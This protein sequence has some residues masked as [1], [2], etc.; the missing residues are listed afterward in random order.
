M[1]NF[2]MTEVAET[3]Y[4]YVT[5]SCSM[6]PEAV[7]AAMSEAFQAVWMYMQQAAIAPKG[8][9][10]SVY[11]T[12]QEDRLTFRAGFVVAKDDLARAGGDIS[13][14]VTPAGE[15]LHFTH[16]GPYSTLRD[17]YALM[18]A[19]IDDSGR[20]VSAPTWEL[21]INDPAQTPAEDLL[22]EVYCSLV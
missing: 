20:S 15:V 21:Y 8:P 10:L 1:P 17:N 3:P 13:G 18:M 19:H 9:A 6:A 5:K 11:Y 7:G 4:L 22:T 16:K 12:Y 2:A 14:D